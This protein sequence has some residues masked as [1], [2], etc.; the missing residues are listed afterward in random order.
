MDFLS[1][2]EEI[3]GEGEGEGGGEGIVGVEKDDGGVW[4]ESGEE[5]GR[6][7]ELGDEDGESEGIDVDG[8]EW[9]TSGKSAIE[10]KVVEGRK[11]LK[12]LVV[13]KEVGE[14]L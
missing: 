2:G 7:V 12:V 9:K 6:R 10:V 5:E 11:M 13:L 8:G 4:E 3:E 14:G 1:G